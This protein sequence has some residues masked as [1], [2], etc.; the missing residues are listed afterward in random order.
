MEKETDIKT[1]LNRALEAEMV[2][3]SLTTKIQHIRE[4]LNEIEEYKK[5]HASIRLDNFFEREAM[6]INPDNVEKE[7]RL[8]SIIDSLEYIF[9]CK[10]GHYKDK[11]ND[12]IDGLNVAVS[13][14][15]KSVD[16]KTLGLFKNS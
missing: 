12:E 11:I 13:R 14:M 8:K 1:L 3:R 2:A 7:N 16:F 5:A 10:V 9:A 4:C 15:P 6:A